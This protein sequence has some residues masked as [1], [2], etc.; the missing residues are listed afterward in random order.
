MQWSEKENICLRDGGVCIT[1]W[2]VAIT[3]QESLSGRPFLF[4]LL[5]TTRNNWAAITGWKWWNLTHHFN[6]EQFSNFYGL[7]CLTKAILPDSILQTPLTLWPCTKPQKPVICL[8]INNL[9]QRYQTH[10]SSGNTFSP[11][12]SQAN[13]TCEITVL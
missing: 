13:Q 12:W 3:C 11:I 9:R 7:T 8:K 2:T 6:L 4:L 10:S 5:S 1:G